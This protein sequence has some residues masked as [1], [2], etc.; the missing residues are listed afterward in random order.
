MI[1]IIAI[2]IIIISIINNVHRISELQGAVM[3]FHSISA[4]ALNGRSPPI[5]RRVR[6]THGR[7]RSVQ[8]GFSSVMGDTDSAE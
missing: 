8:R 7:F 1:I 5:F 4:A 6:G 3:G 2:I